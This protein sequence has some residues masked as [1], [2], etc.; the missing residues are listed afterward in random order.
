MHTQKVK[1]HMPSMKLFWSIRFRCKSGCTLEV[2]HSGH[3]TALELV[4]GTGCDHMGMAP[5][6]DTKLCLIHCVCSVSHL[7]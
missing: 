6:A 4:L 7:L 3:I 5:K 1:A 2:L